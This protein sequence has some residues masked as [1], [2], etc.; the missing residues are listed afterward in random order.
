MPI[1]SFA[2]PSSL[3]GAL[4]LVVACDG[5]TT[6]QPSVE[7]E[8]GLSIAPAAITLLVGQE[9]QLF[10][11]L[12]TS[13]AGVQPENA[14]I[15]WTTSDS[16]IAQIRENGIVVPIAPGRVAVEALYNGLRAVTSINVVTAPACGI[17]T[18]TTAQAAGGTS[19]ALFLELA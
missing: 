2:R 11:S 6:L 19:T 16:R 7:D 17:T 9:K 4:L 8:P 1:R 10:A 12:T 14:A 13:G 15:R 5:S 3:V 18:P